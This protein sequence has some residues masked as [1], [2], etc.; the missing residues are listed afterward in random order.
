MTADIIV[1]FLISISP[2]GE[3]RVGIPYGVVNGL[4]VLWSFIIGW[5]ANILVF[6]LF[7]KGITVMN[8]FLWKHKKYKKS[9]V[10]LSKKAK[11][12]TQNSIAK[13]GT[14]GLMIFVMI[15]LPITGAYI[16][17]IAA[18]I[19]NMEYKKSLLAVTVG[20]TISSL[21]IASGMYFG[22]S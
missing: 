9:A 4:P 20:V 8:Q 17:T 11:N 12:K 6:P 21:I 2:L 7:Y 1:T 3:A 16:G 15:P 10:Y 13:Y 19:F 18:Y 5:T 14:W 22:F